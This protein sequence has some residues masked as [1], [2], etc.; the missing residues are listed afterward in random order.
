MTGVF[1]V[2][3]EGNGLYYLST[4][5]LGPGFEQGSFDIVVNGGFVICTATGGL[6]FHPQGACS[7]LAELTEGASLLFEP[8]SNSVA[9]VSTHC[10]KYNF[11][12]G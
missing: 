4:Y 7:G 2:P 8:F 1:T 5:L 12:V 3:P 10:L 6:G 9:W 11:V